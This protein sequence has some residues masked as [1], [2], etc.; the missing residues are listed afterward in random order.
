[1]SA[2]VPPSALTNRDR[3]LL[4]AV[5]TGRVEL[6]RSAEPDVFVD[7]VPWCDQFGARKLFHC[8]LIRYGRSDA[9]GKR[10][11]AVLANP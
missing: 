11:P 2:T 1:M 9:P 5:A 7:G 8:G 6:T 4:A 10:V 3:G